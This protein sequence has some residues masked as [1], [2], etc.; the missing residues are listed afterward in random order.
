MI[1]TVFDSESLF[2]GPFTCLFKSWNSAELASEPSSAA[3]C[4]AL[5]AGG[6]Y[7]PVV[8]AAEFVVAGAYGFSFLGAMK[9][10]PADA[11]PPSPSSSSSSPEPNESSK[12]EE[13]ISS[14]EEKGFSTV[15]S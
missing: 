7:L 10:S 14:S 5:K 12:S 9:V 3:C 6:T 4:L 13:L 15:S 8:V 11:G 2:N 1:E